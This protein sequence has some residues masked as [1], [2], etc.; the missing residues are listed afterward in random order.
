MLKQGDAL[1]ADDKLKFI[2][3]NAVALIISDTRGRFTLK[4]PERIEKTEG[5]LTVFVKNALITNQQNRL[6][7]RSVT[8]QAA[9]KHLDKYLGSDDFNV[10][11]EKLVIKLSKKY[12][13][14]Y[15][16]YNI[17]AKYYL[18]DKKYVKEL[19]TKN[20]T[21]IFS[22]SMFELPDSEKDYLE[23]VYIY[24]TNVSTGEK[25]LIT[26]INIRFVEKQQLEKEFITIIEK[27]KT[28]QNS[29][30]EIKSLLVDYFIE[31]YGKTD[32]YYLNEY[33]SQLIMDNVGK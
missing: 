11:G 3:K 9:I 8:T 25:D 22:C 28:A 21:I 26:N 15:K 12:Y 27:F 10:I 18:N 2:Q 24:K 6:S 32:D 23:E 13:P 7:T 20:Q 29:K 14:V 4:Y 17:T 16:G 31:F 30:S 1:K 5:A 19:S 33:T